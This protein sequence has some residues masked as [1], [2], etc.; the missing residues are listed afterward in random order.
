MKLEQILAS[1]SNSTTRARLQTWQMSIQSHLLWPES[2]SQK[3]HRGWPIDF[4][5]PTRAPEHSFSRSRDKHTR[6]S[7]SDWIIRMG[8][9]LQ[10][11][12]E[13]M[14]VV[15]VVARGPLAGARRV[16]SRHNY[17]CRCGRPSCRVTA[18]FQAVAGARS[19]SP[20][21]AGGSRY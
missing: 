16:H 9:H 21:I 20:D 6:K 17:C 7:L 15:L 3:F 2:H 18:Q 14:S 10:E 1:R 8:H 13:S 12:V 4:W 19:E 11:Y 5:H